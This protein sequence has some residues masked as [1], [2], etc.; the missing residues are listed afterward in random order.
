MEPSFLFKRELNLFLSK[1]PGYYF[2]SPLEVHSEFKELVIVCDSTPGK[3][4]PLARS[5]RT[6]LYLLPFS[7]MPQVSFLTSSRSFFFFSSPLLS[8]VHVLSLFLCCK[9]LSFHFQVKCPCEKCNFGCLLSYIECNII[10][11]RLLKYVFFSFFFSAN[12]AKRHLFFLSVV[13]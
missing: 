8:H 1:Q 4:K 13:K 11:L 2:C 5:L 10:T 6:V 3:H 9:A 7:Q 12:T